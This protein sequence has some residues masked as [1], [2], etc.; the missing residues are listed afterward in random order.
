MTS[1]A[2]SDAYACALSIRTALGGADWLPAPRREPEGARTRRRLLPDREIELAVVEQLG[3]EPLLEQ[4][5]T[6]LDEH[7][8][9]ERRDRSASR[10]P[11]DGR[12]DRLGGDLAGENGRGE[13]RRGER[14][15]QSSWHSPTLR[16][17]CERVNRARLADPQGECSASVIPSERRESRGSALVPL[18]QIGDCFDLA[19]NSPSADVVRNLTDHAAGG[20]M[21]TIAPLF[22]LLLTLAHRRRLAVDTPGSSARGAGRAIRL[23]HVYRPRLGLRRAPGRQGRVRE[24]DPLRLLSRPQLSRASATTT[25]SSGRPSPTSPASRSSAARISSTGRRSGT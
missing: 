7:A 6:M 15:E 25:T 22:A 4:A 10:R 9:D 8:V 2:W 14:E 20:R 18:G 5:S 24:P 13:E 12:G 21:R 19:S 11:V 17:P 16:R 1:G 23:V 3:A